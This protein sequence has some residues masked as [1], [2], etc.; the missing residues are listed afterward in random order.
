MRRRNLQHNRFYVNEKIV[1]EE[2][3][4]RR[5]SSI[6]G[7][8][9]GGRQK[10]EK[11]WDISQSVWPPRAK[12]AD[13][14][15]VHD[16][17]D[18][19]LKVLDCDWKYAL[20]EHGTEA[21]I[22]KKCKAHPGSQA[23]VEA[24]HAA[25]VEKRVMIYSLFDY[26]ATLGTGEPFSIQLNSFTMFVEECDLVDSKN[27]NLKKSALAWLDPATFGL[28]HGSARTLRASSCRKLKAHQIVCPT[29]AAN[30]DQLFLAVNA[31]T[32]NIRALDRVGWLQVLLKIAQMK[33]MADGTIDEYGEALRTLLD[34]DIL[35][36]ADSH[37][38]HDATTLR[39]RYCYTQEVDA[40]LRTHYDSLRSIFKVSPCSHSTRGRR[41]VPV[42]VINRA[43]DLQG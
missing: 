32:D 21:F 26:Y 41:L 23:A 36:H 34:V 10:V 30:F 35:Q 14:K 25:F 24:C 11:E 9:G 43:C 6:H 22:K 8:G 38:L 4:V 13:S 1:E 27:P 16:T 40:V 3:I 2:Q 42:R 29:P 31:G 5:R 39:E 28:R 18:H 12:Y 19:M 37:A 17:E 33:Y 20:E 7:G 15:S